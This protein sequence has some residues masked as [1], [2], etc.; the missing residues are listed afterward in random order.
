VLIRLRKKLFMN[1][2]NHRSFITIH[3][4][5][6]AIILFCIFQIDNLALEAPFLAVAI[7]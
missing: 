3:F 5:L 6:L 4:V 7:Y 1:S 2:S